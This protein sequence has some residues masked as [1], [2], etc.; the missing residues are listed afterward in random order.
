MPMGSLAESLLL[1]ELRLL[2]VK[3]P[4]HSGVITFYVEK[5][6][7]MEVCPR[8]AT[9]GY[10]VY[11]RRWSRVRDS[12]IRARRV[13]LWILKRRFSC[14]RC[15]RPFTEPVPGISKGARST[16][17]FRRNIQWACEHFGDLKSVM[18]Q[19][20]CSSGYVYKAHYEELERKR[21]MRVHPW[22]EVVGIDEHFFRHTGDRS[23]DF[24][25]VV[26]DY[27][28]RAMFEVVEGRQTVQLKHALS[29][30]PGRDNVRT[31]VMDMYEPYRKFSR[32]FFPQATIVADK[33]HVLRLLS[34]WINKRRKEITGDK[35]THPIRWM[36]LTNYHRLSRQQRW[37]LFR[38][39]DDKPELREV[40]QF[41]ESLHRLYRTRTSPDR[42]GFNWNEGS[43]T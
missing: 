22:P 43:I 41:K 23:R 24:V 33:F 25:S 28:N 13:W 42:V 7:E 32:E 34:P 14:K 20:R 21:R 2:E 37:A 18:R 27:R 11:D 30:I 31:V 1:P 39:L 17:R 4:R 35:R 3:D 10:T 26:V 36:L 8:C 12:N 5:T 29:E 16:Q 40:Y 6:S 38:W 19:Y 9:P 15:K